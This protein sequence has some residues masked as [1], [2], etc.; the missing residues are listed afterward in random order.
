M[1]LLLS[2]GVGDLENPHRQIK[3][4]PTKKIYQERKRD[5]RKDKG[6]VFHNEVSQFYFYIELGGGGI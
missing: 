5:S 4:A 2:R 1:F 3:G 6:G